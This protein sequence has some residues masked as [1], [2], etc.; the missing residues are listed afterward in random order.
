VKLTD[1]GVHLVLLLVLPPL[2][3]GVI[4]KVKAWFAGRK[5][6]P[7]LQLYLDLW[8]LLRKGAVY[9]RT[10]T[11]VFRAGPTVSLAAVLV[12]SLVMPLAGREAPLHFA[13]DMVLFAYML[14]LARFVTVIAAL[15]TGSSFEGMGGSRE[16]AFGAIAE[17]AL[18]LSLVVLARNAGSAELS[19]ALAAI[20]APT[21]STT[22]PAFLLIGL[23][24]TA[25]LLAENCRIPVDDP[26][27][28]LEL[29]MIHEVMVLD[30]SGP[31]FA[32]ILH[33][34]AVKLMLFAVLLVRLVLP[35]HQWPWWAAALGLI[36]GL[37]L[38]A[39]LVGCIESIIARSRLLRV[40]RLLLLAVLLSSLGVWV[41]VAQSLARH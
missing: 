2:L 17:P 12:A 34:A 27:T 18:F 6:P 38:L 23:S 8:K 3:P 39:G 20:G 5:G 30:H 36:G 31:D 41:M 26:T 14:G 24:L 1:I 4:A 19:Q 40:P 10:T 37:V 9:S 16:V 11:W 22:A 15:D 7:V 28:H 32:F 35:V 25:V 33:G 13:G 21:W 29:T